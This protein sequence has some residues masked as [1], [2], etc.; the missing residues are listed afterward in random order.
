MYEPYGFREG[1]A[2]YS[3]RNTIDDEIKFNR[4]ID[5]QQTDEAFTSAEYNK[6]LESVIFKNANG[7][8]V[9]QLSMTDIVASDLVKEAKYDSETQKLIIEFDN[10]DIVTIDLND[11]I[12]F[13]EA[14]DGLA[15]D[16][17][18]FSIKIADDSEEFLQVTSDG[19][20]N[21]GIQNAIDAERDRAMVAEE[22]EK[23][24]RIDAITAEKERA[25]GAEN[26]L[27]QL[28]DAE[29]RRAKG[30]EKRI[31]DT[32]GTGF[33]TALTET[34]TQKFNDLSA[35]LSS[36]TSTRTSQD[37]DL[38]NKIGL[39]ER[40]RELYDNLIRADLTSEI[41]RAKEIEEGLS[42][43]ISAETDA[44]IEMDERLQEEIDK[45]ADKSEVYTKTETDEA[46][47]T[48]I[49][50]VLDN[51][52]EM[53]DTLKEIADYIESDSAASISML[54]QISENKED[55]ATLKEK[56]EELV[57]DIQ[58]KA[59]KSSLN[60]HETNY[61]VHVTV[62]DKDSWNSKLD[63]S[64][65]SDMATMSWVNSQGF[66]TDHQDIS[67]LATKEELNEVNAMLLEKENEIYN[68]TKIVGDLGGN[69]TYELPNELGKS[70][71]SLMLNNGTVKLTEDVTTGRFG[72][73]ITAKNT[74]K[75]NLNN[76]NLTI[77]GLTL[78]SSTAAIL[79][80][81]TEDVT[82]GGKGIVDAGEGVCIMT[83]GADSVV[84]LTGSTTVYQTNRPGAELI[85]CYSG[86]I[87]ISNGT[88]R[89]NGTS[90]YTLNCYDANYQN[91]TAKI[92]VTGGKFYD[93]DPGN[94]T[95]EG[96]NT[97]FLAEGYHTEASTV[98]EDGV[99]HTV[100][101]VKKN[102]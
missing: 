37:N 75:L 80:R 102:S 28:I 38:Q 83:N 16:G 100:Y 91:G 89:N 85:Y 96:P 48:E 94:N 7:E 14:G 8:A 77:T 78:T 70:F 97:S 1:E 18:K 26:T 25:E 72:P 68:L 34:V 86:T 59:D 92:I 29:A 74:V 19:I 51:A 101:T 53:F 88:F 90:N 87:N 6:G 27:G 52:P 65:I 44:R 57:N 69:V 20:K 11:L 63:A 13:Q 99:E 4:K 81:G 79:V 73:G 61:N 41:N 67:G 66:L 2:Y 56:D 23:N 62:E 33:T 5:K 3:L 82:I 12:N 45:K 21:V 49:S 31:T 17:N 54:A 46:I 50:K 43:G 35:A 39:E 32:I 30:E 24:E 71:N 9:G 58:Q 76:H 98:A 64:A 15:L 84:N 47:S 42:R 22:R 60:A 95:A 93:F 40:Q 36:E 10:G 55:I